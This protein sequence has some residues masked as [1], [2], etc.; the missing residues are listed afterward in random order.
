MGLSGYFNTSYKA[1]KENDNVLRVSYTVGGNSAY[2]IYDFL[3]RVMFSRTG[4]S[5]G[6]HFVTPFSQLDR[7]SLVEMHDQLVA[8]GGKPPPLPAEPATGATVKKFNL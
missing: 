7:E 3:A 4:S 6:G 5:D 2:L 8:L 1:A